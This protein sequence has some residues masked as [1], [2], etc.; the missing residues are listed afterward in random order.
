MHV[1]TSLMNVGLGGPNQG[2]LRLQSSCTQT[3][4]FTGQSTHAQI[5]LWSGL[6]RKLK[7][8]QGTTKIQ[9]STSKHN[10]TQKSLQ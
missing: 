8:T 1:L 10:E 6:I 4:T 7:Q 3:C 2:V 9:T 5:G